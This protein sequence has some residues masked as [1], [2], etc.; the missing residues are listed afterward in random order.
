MNLYGLNNSQ[1]IT[2][3]CRSRLLL[4]TFFSLF[5][6]YKIVYSVSSPHRQKFWVFSKKEE[7]QLLKTISCSKN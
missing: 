3:S 2:V 6:G 1:Y 7:N 4:F 5:L